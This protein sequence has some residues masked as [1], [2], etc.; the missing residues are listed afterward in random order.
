MT[1]QV[2]G[3]GITLDVRRTHP[4]DAT[5]I[6]LA[7][8]AEE[9]LHGGNGG[10]T[11]PRGL[12]TYRW[13]VSLATRDESAVITGIVDQLNGGAVGMGMVVRHADSA[14]L[15]GVFVAPSF[16]GIGVG[17]SIVQEAR[18]VADCVTLRTLALPGDRRT[19]NLFEQAGMPAQLIV[20]G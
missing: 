1:S 7:E 5:L 10:A 16:R 3:H 15:H 20:A 17:R 4:S 11:P 12:A 6:A 13:L 9:E 14:L 8:L 19:K 18:A 2:I